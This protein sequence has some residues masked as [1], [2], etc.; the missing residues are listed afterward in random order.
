[1]KNCLC[2]I[3]CHVYF[4][5]Y[6]STSTELWKGSLGTYHMLFTEL[7][8]ILLQ[9][10]PHVNL[11]IKSK[12]V[13]NI[14]SCTTFDLLY[15]GINCVQSFK[16]ITAPTI[17]FFARPPSAQFLPSPYIYLFFI[18]SLYLQ[19]LSLFHY[20]HLS[21]SLVHPLPIGIF[22]GAELVAK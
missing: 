14:E 2:L 17:R 4:V 6:N 8:F 20:P 22:F 21:L 15:T 11:Q 18:S 5:I 1:M 12:K 10:T 19:N 3:N 9:Y 7:M 16:A 13:S